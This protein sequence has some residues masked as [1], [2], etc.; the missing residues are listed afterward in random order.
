MDLSNYIDV[1]F[2][3]RHCCWFCGEPA[4]QQFTFPH[5]AIALADCAHPTLSLP[6]CKECKSFARQTDVDNIW[7]VKKQVKKLLVNTY[8]QHLAIGI[9]WTK[10][11]LANSEFE[12]G[13][14]AGF[15]RSAWFMYEVA[16]ARVNFSGWR[17]VLDGLYLA[18]EFIKDPF[19]FDG[20]EYPSVE[21]AI[22]HYS[23]NFSLSSGYLAEVLAC[24]G[25]EN[26]SQAVRHCRLMVGS[27]PQEQKQALRALVFPQ[28]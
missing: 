14:F 4:D 18:E 27:T 5:K 1:P 15:Q 11:E 26:F 10:Q 20:V 8:R 22:E 19:I 6:S 28:N 17:I 16:K 9:N 7:Q 12:G 21:D 23:K 2:Q 24:L 25:N 3:Y 13:N